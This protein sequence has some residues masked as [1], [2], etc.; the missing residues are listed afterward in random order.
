[1]QC[2]KKEGGRHTDREMGS[3]VG[4]K[5]YTSLVKLKGPSVFWLCCLH[6]LLKKEAW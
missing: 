2:E 1:M 3:L 6:T 4:G 5:I